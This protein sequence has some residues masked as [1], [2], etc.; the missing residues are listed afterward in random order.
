ME[1]DDKRE[2]EKRK[3][4][5]KGGEKNKE[6][7]DRRRKEREERRRNEG[8]IMKERRRREEKGR[9]RSKRRQRGKRDVELEWKAVW[10]S[11]AGI[12]GLLEN[13]P[14]HTSHFVDQETEAQKN[15]EFAPVTWA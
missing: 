2:I 5:G 10:K 3:V 11:T 7:R 6:K 13:L 8:K 9:G 14:V 4:R 15:R 1:A 12:T